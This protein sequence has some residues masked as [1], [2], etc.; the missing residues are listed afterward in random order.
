MWRVCLWPLALYKDTFFTGV[1]AGVHSSSGIA[2]IPNKGLVDGVVYDKLEQSFYGYGIGY[3][4]L[5][6]S[7]WSVSGMV[8]IEHIK[9]KYTNE[10]QSLIKKSVRTV[11]GL[12][13]GSVF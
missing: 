6:L 4:W 3:R 12:V 8:A 9:D 7:G 2:P 5:L 10:Q 13:F 11:P 1:Y